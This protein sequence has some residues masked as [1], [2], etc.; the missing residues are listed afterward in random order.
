MPAPQ[1]NQVDPSHVIADL[2]GRIR[3][4]ENKYN[5]L[6]ERLL[7]INQNM[8]EEYKKIIT[9]MRDLS[10]ETKKARLG[11]QTT[12]DVVKDIVKEMSI[13]AKKDQ[14]KVLEKYMDMI[15][16][17]QLVTDEQLETRLE[18]F[19]SEIKNK[20]TKEVK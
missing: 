16:V 13:F 3:A 4:L 20:N 1:F 5:I 6:T 18:R 8:I 11:T 10:T 2:N 12:Q 14:I 17:I 15:N 19:K 9:G 7:V